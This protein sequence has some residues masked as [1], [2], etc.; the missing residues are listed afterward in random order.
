MAL[1]GLEGGRA[2][3]ARA[4]LRCALTMFE[5]LDSF[6]D[7]LAGELETPLAIGVGIHTGEAIVGRMGPPKTP[8]LS[9]V[10]DSVNT[11][12]RLEGTTK[13]LGVPLVVSVEALRAAGIATSMPLKDI[14]L[15][16]RASTIAVAPLEEASLREIL[17]DDR[18]AK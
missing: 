1:F 16:G 18:K 7:R 5:R 17:L 14:S 12:A 15:P 11:T 4:A 3:G 8:I 6:N 2:E 13:E 10:G 9:A